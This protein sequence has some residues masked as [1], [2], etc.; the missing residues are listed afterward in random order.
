VNT[1]WRDFADVW[2]LSGTH[3]VNGDELQTALRVVAEY[4]RVQLA[5][6]ADV[7]DGYAALAQRR[8][9]AWRRK[10]QTLH[11]PEEFNDLLYA[12]IAFADPALTGHVTD[13]TWNPT[14]RNW[15]PLRG[16]RRAPGAAQA[17]G[18]A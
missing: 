18:G 7:L 9:G 2:T 12:V 5:R 11:F 6:L 13:L 8:W 3:P 1:R 10:Q 15:Q 4:G 14:A 17:S 16:C